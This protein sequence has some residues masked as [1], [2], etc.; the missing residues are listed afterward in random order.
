[1]RFFLFVKEGFNEILFNLGGLRRY[2]FR[3]NRFK[4]SD[5]IVVIVRGII[6]EQ[7]S[8]QTVRHTI[9]QHKLDIATQITHKLST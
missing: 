2:I 3:E 1:M 5:S 6:G 8:D 4:W 7:H 9:R